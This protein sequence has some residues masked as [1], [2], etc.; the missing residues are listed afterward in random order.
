MSF[1]APHNKQLKQFMVVLRKDKQFL[2]QSIKD[3][4]NSKNF[5]AQQQEKLS[6][7]RLAKK[8]FACQK[9]PSV[10]WMDHR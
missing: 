1:F 2:S 3:L 4:S 9:K 6:N 7:L 10:V 8:P 5:E